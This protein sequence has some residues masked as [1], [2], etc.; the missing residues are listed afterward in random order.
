MAVITPDRYD[1]TVEV[2]ANNFAHDEPLCQA[3]GVTW[4][5]DLE[6]LKL[7]KLKNNV[8]I[9]MISKDT[10]EI[11]AILITGVM[12][13]A[14][15][16]EDLSDIENEPLRSL[17]TFLTHRDKEVNF[18]ERYKVD[19]AI[20]FSTLTV[21]KKYRCNQVGGHLIAVCV[22]MSRELGFKVIKC[23]GTSNF[24]QRIAEKLGFDIVLE[25]PYASYFY[26]GRPIIEGTGEHKMT[27]VYAMKI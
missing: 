19:E 13:K 4:S 3:F 6:K 5:K 2:M 22:A 7:D 21:N 20:H 26:N 25:I 16:P 10:N 18:F 8:S 14:D 12:K 24:S 27:K 1:E 11:M 23:E 15:S 17:L 9:C